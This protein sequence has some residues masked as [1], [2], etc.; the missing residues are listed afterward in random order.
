MDFYTIEAKNWDKANYN[1][2]F[3]EQLQEYLSSLFIHTSI[4]LDS[5]SLKK[6]FLYFLAGK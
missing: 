1:P 3:E 6:L 2:D 4:F 5:N